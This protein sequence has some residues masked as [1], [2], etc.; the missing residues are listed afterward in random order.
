M[1]ERVLVTGASGFVA[2]HVILQLLDKGYEVC[3][4][5]RSL[6]RADEVRGILAK[7]DP[8]ASSLEFIEADLGA[9]PGWASAVEGCTYV[10]HVASPFPAVHPKDE[11]E[12]IRPAVDGALRVLKA[13]KNAGVKRVVMTSSLAA[14]AYGHGDKRPDVADETLWSKPEGPDNTPYTKS[15]TLAERAAWDYVNGDGKSLELAVIN[16]TGI[17]GPALSKD[18][19][20]SLE[21]PIR[22]MN[23]KTPGLPRLGFSI[24]DVRDVAAC[25]VAAMTVPAAAGERFIASEDFLWFTECADI[26]RKAFPAYDDKIPKQQVPDFVIRLMSMVQPIYKQTLT[27]L[28]RTRR[29]SNAKATRVLGVHFRPA[30]EAL[31]ASAQSLVD[32]GVV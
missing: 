26:L 31:I 4:T 6:K 21:I 16:P 17:F 30:K 23:G 14:I 24:V 1:G 11:N 2:Q 10:Q 5:L 29:A 28:G 3:G 27:E 9:D 15:K 19:S 32:L 7:H 8:R 20:T 12:L 18:V 13:A 25:Q 22:L